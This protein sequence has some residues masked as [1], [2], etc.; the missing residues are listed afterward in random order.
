MIDTEIIVY[1]RRLERARTRQMI[2]K[3]FDAIQHLEW[4]RNVIVSTHRKGFNDIW[5]GM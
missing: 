1:K 5:I 3:A 4:L 2:V